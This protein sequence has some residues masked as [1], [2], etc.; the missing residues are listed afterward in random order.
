VFHS[1]PKQDHLV[2]FLGASLLMGV[3]EGTGPVPPDQAAFS[4][5][6][7]DDFYAGQQLIRTFV[8][9]YT[10]SKTGLGAEIVNY[11]RTAEEAIKAKREWFINSRRKNAPPPIDA[12][13]ESRHSHPHFRLAHG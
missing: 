12:R 9:T 6:Q 1:T 2:A 10:G 4:P 3:T 13:S 8:A 11:Y 5:T 7:A